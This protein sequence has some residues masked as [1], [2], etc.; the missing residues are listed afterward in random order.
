MS[1]DYRK[2]I[3][4]V[5]SGC[6]PSNPIIFDVGCNINKII[7]EDEVWIENW[8]DDFTLLFLDRFKDAKC[9]AIE[10]LHWQEFENRWG[11]DERVELIKLALSDKNGN[12]FIFYPGD[13]HV[14]SSFYMQDDFLGEPLHT[15]KVKCK[16]LDSLCKELS[17]DRIDYLKIDTEGAEL[18]IIEGSR[19]LLERHSIKY[20]QFEYG[21]PDENIPSVDKILRCLKYY[22]Y[23]EVLTSGREKLWADREYYDL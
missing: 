11:D 21:L 12:E 6:L 5:S 10:P 20:I 2:C 17:L 9:Y 1:S 13:R 3:E 15:E 8:N 19:N 18:K 23:H 7:E 4:A 16:T 14:L 22:G